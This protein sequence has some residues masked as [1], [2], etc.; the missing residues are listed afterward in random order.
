MSGRDDPSGIDALERLRHAVALDLHVRTYGTVIAYDPATGT[1]SV[2]PSRRARL[3]SGA[4]A[5][6]SPLSMVPVLWPR[7]A[8]M[9]FRGRLDPGDEVDLVVYDRE[10]DGF[11]TTGGI[12]DPVSDRMHSISD[13]A[14][15]IGGLASLARPV[16]GP[17]LAGAAAE[18]WIGKEDGSSAI[19]IQ[20]DGPLITIGSVA[21]TEFVLLGTTLAAAA[22]AAETILNV[23]PEAVEPTAP[24]AATLA[25]ACQV[26]ILSLTAAIQ[27]AVATKVIAE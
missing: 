19:R 26:A 8:G 15:E 3:Q 13:C 10:I 9:T 20:I 7:F 25:N 1:A 14:V 24:S 12:V 22:L 17:A 27:S 2:Q 4:I 23:V 6:L 5:D 21:A 11:L 18:L 16:L